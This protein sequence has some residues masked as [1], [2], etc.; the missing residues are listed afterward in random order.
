MIAGQRVAPLAGAWIETITGA[1]S[2]TFLAVAPL[3][4]AWIETFW[5]SISPLSPQVAP[6]AGAWIETSCGQGDRHLV[7]SPPSRGRGLKHYESGLP[8]V[9]NVRRPPRGGVD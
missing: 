3:A 8:V 2:P 1:C 5:L 6:L 7:G 9:D 4:G